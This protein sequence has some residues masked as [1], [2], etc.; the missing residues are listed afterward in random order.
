MYNK[1]HFTL[2]G[3]LL[4]NGKPYTPE[5]PSSQPWLQQAPAGNAR[6][7]VFIRSSEF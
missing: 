5:E 2:S 4:T 6:V 7:P 3:P 1:L